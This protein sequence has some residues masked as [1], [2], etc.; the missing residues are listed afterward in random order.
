MLVDRAFSLVHAFRQQCIMCC[1]PIHLD[2]SLYKI[3]HRPIYSQFYCLLH[4]HIE[5]VLK[6]IYYSGLHAW[7]SNYIGWRSHLI[8]APY[9]YIGHLTLHICH[10]FLIAHNRF[11]SMQA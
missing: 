4:I 6:L 1:R 8:C 5:D 7:S 3:N 2:G 11:Q 10:L 9:I